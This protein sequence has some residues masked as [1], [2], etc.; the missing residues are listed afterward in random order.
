MKDKGFVLA[1]IIMVFML[2]MMPKEVYGQ[3][4]TSLNIMSFNFVWNNQTKANDRLL[5]G[6][7]K[8]QEIDIVGIQECGRTA[9]NKIVTGE[10]IKSKLD[11]DTLNWPMF[12]KN[13]KETIGQCI[14]SRYPIKN[15]EEIITP[16]YDSSH[17]DVLQLFSINHPAAGQVWFM[18]VHDTSS[19]RKSTSKVIELLG[20]RF[21]GK[22]VFVMGDF[23][24]R[25][26]NAK[27]VTI[28]TILNTACPVTIP[29]SDH[30]LL[31]NNTVNVITHPNL[32]PGTTIDY[33]FYPKAG[34]RLLSG[35]V[36]VNLFISDH[37]PVIGKFELEAK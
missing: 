30:A 19:E 11:G 12:L 25:P 20:S 13:H 26:M 27:I 14:L 29:Y 6:R 17:H 1:I 22:M 10:Y 28:K 9:D 36:G 35:Y 32:L 16:G 24:A 4:I 21:V 8:N 18:V 31:C 15:Y 37:Y 5:A 34:W 2:S 23:N 7:I 3:A 33:I